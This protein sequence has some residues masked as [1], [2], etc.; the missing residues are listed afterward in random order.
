[1]SQS[2]DF[3]KVFDS[4]KNFENTIK[5]LEKQVPTPPQATAPVQD[6]RYPINT[7]NPQTVEHIIRIPAYLANLEEDFFGSDIGKELKQQ[8]LRLVERRNLEFLA[9]VEKTTGFPCET[10]NNYRAQISQVNEKRYPVAEKQETPQNNA[11]GKKPQK[12]VPEK[13]I[14]PVG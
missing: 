4:M 1:M 12:D 8:E 2:L 3:S 10:L 13:E 14:T 5:N 7:Q 9:F 11:S 6:S